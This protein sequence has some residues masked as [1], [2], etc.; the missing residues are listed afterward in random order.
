M[1]LTYPIVSDEDVVAGAYLEA[2]GERY[3]PLVGRL[4][5]SDSYGV[6]RNQMLQSGNGGGKGNKY[7]WVFSNCRAGES[8]ITEL[9]SNSNSFV[10]FFPSLII[11]HLGAVQI[12]LRPDMIL[13][14]NSKY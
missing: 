1:K 13:N 4:I 7:S 2:E 6:S 8:P 5:A 9:S 11:F 14:K 3:L 12:L 10:F